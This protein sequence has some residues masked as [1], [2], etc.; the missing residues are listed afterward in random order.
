MPTNGVSVWGYLLKID[1]LP[2]GAS[3]CIECHA[4]VFLGMG[5]KTQ[6]RRQLGRRFGRGSCSA[7]KGYWLLKEAREDE[8]G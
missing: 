2:E 7:F 4:V 5:T 1:L 3:H 8:W 6:S